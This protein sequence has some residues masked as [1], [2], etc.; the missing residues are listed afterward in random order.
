MSFQIFCV[1][2]LESI[3]SCLISDKQPKTSIL[4]KMKPKVNPIFHSPSPQQGYAVI[5]EMVNFLAHTNKNMD[6]FFFLVLSG[7]NDK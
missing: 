2:K 4:A 6:T 7:H 1:Q 3:V 5:F